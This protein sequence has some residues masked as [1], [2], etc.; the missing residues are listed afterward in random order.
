VVAGKGLEQQ[1]GSGMRGLRVVD[2]FSLA[3]IRMSQVRGDSQMVVGFRRC[4]KDTR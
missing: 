1:G 4:T 3:G 2:R